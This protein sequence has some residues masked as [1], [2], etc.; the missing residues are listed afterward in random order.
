MSRTDIISDG[1]TVL[2]NAYMARKDDVIIPFSRLLLDAAAILK[3]EGYIENYQSIKQNNLPFIKIFLKYIKNKPAITKI[4][5][6]SIPSRKF[7]VGKNEIPNV[8]DGAGIAIVTTSKG[9]MT[10]TDA[11]SA[12]VGG[13][14][15]CFVV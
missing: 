8:D 9:V 12:G 14:V 6:V 1:L 10:G 15:I 7:Y 5:K 3:R 2:R 4:K 13:E 11:R